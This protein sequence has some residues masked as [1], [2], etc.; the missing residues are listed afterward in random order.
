MCGRYAIVS[1]VEKVQ[2]TFKVKWRGASNF[3]ANTN[4]SHGDLAPIISSDNPSEI[5]L[6]QFGYSPSW[7]KKQV[8]LI[9][10]RAE[11]DNNKENDP[12]YTGSKGIISKPMFRKSIR[13]QR[14]L[15]PAD[16]F[17]EGPKNEN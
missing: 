4:V 13:N 12:L 14:C 3:E 9:N 15:V 2:K 5:Q 16:C 1:K 11:G 7:S 17:I 6:S 8:Y 10:A